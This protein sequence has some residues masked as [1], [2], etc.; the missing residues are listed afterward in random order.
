M[1]TLV[2][3][4]QWRIEPPGPDCL[5]ER[6]FSAMLTKPVPI[7]ILLGGFTLAVMGGCINAVGLLCAQS[8]A[9]SHLSGTITSLGVEAAQ[10]HYALARHAALIVTFFFLGS[11]LS[12][13]II[14]QSALKAGRRYGGTLICES[15]LLFAA[16]YLLRHDSEGGLYTAAMACGLQ[17]GMAT[18]YSGAVIRTTHVTGIITDLG[19]AI[20]LTAR[21]LKADWRRMRLYLVL[22]GG[23][24]TGASIGALG[25]VSYGTDTLFFPAVFSGISGIGYTAWKHFWRPVPM[26][27]RSPK[28]LIAESNSAV[29]RK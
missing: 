9:I 18:S 4:V 23:F 3:I 21:G 15:V 14:R 29:D 2:G 12:G 25:F 20:G 28:L 10:H 24:V 16:A 13:V 19:I 27:V 11:V 6:L 7:W 5:Y 17:N 26:P 1:P 22:L 8:H